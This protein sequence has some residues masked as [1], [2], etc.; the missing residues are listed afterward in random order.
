MQKELTIQVTPEI[1]S[2]SEALQHFVSLKAGIPLSQIRHIEILKRS[3]DARQKNIKINLKVLVF[4]DEDF[5]DLPILKPDYKDVSN[6][7]PVLIIGAGPAGLFAALRCI[8]LGKK[9][10]CYRKG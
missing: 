8:E 3:I 1:A 9:T 2:N 6:K 10:H 5:E 4:V 7:S